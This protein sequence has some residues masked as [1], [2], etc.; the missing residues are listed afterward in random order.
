MQII[1]SDIDLETEFTSISDRFQYFSSALDSI[2]LQSDEVEGDLNIKKVSD[3]YLPA[4]SCDREV[5]SIAAVS[6]AGS[7]ATTKSI[8]TVVAPAVVA[9]AAAAAGRGISPPTAV[10]A[11]PIKPI[12]SPMVALKVRNSLRIKDDVTTTIP[13]RVKSVQNKSGN[14]GSNRLPTP[15]TASQS[16]NVSWK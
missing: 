1:N 11:S 8:P 5:R 6:D 9:P 10:V 7:I 14:R 12:A 13:V 4:E 16:A 15:P 2:L 3:S